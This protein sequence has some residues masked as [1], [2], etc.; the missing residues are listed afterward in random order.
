MKVA[1]LSVALLFTILLCTPEDAQAFPGALLEASGGSL[2]H[3][4]LKLGRVKR[5]ALPLSVRVDDVL[6]QKR[7]LPELPDAEVIVQPSPLFPN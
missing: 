1:V 6:Q 2:L 7:Q 4:G 5:A 3:G